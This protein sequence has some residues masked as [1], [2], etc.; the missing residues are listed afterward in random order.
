MLE[1]EEHRKG[2][3]AANEYMRLFEQRY[4]TPPLLSLMDR[5]LMK[6]LVRAHGLPKILSM[7]EQYL[8]MNGDRNWFITKGHDL[9]TFKD[10]LNQVLIA[11][12]REAKQGAQT[13][14]GERIQVTFH[15]DQCGSPFLLSCYG[16]DLSRRQLCEKCLEVPFS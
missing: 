4:Q 6:D 10:S 7:L 14:E 11:M 1:I 13:G 9:R 2:E 8:K 12:P 15:C 16:A 3:E 5:T